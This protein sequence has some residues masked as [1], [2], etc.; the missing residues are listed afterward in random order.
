MAP[1][2]WTTDDQYNFFTGHVP[3]YEIYQATMKRYQPFWDM[4]TPLFLEK[5]PILPTG[6]NVNNLNKKEFKEY[7]K[8]LARLYKVS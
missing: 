3:L 2:T 4:I 6:K 7:S 8:K 5:W 1:K